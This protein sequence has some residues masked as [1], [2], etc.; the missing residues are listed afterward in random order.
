LIVLVGDCF[1]LFQMQLTD[2]PR[3]TQIIKPSTQFG[4][5]K[6]CCGDR[7]PDYLGTLF[8]FRIRLALRIREMARVTVV[9]TSTSP[10]CA[11]A[12]IPL[13]SVSKPGQAAAWT[14]PLRHHDQTSSVAN[15]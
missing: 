11:A 6:L 12:A 15:G 4:D 1:T 3:S 14:D 8:D 13:N 2:V 9:K 7:C 10:C 5:P